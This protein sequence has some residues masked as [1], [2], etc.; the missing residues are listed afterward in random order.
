MAKLPTWN[1]EPVWSAS[2]KLGSVITIEGNE[3]YFYEHH[4]MSPDDE[5]SEN[6]PVSRGYYLIG[7]QSYSDVSYII[8]VQTTY[9][10]HFS[11][12]PNDRPLNAIQLYSGTQDKD[13]LLN[14]AETKYFY[15]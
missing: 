8:K 11:E 13:Y 9:M 14:A 10:N 12:D 1:N 7:I 2:L 15:F 4:S 6:A 5:N 3:P